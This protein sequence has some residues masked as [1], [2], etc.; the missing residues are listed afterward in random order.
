MQN[1]L[2]LINHAG[3][4]GTERYVYSLIANAE[5]F[6]VK[7]FFAYHEKGLLCDR[8]T[9]L[10]GVSVFHVPMRSPFDFKAARAIAAIC[11]EHQIEVIHTNY[12]RENYNAIIAKQRHLKTLK[13]VYTNHFVIHNSAAVKL[14]NRMMTK[15]DH[16]IISVCQ[17]G[18]EQLKENGND[19]SKIVV[20]HNAVEPEIWNPGA[21]YTEI[22]SKARSAYGIT[23]GEKLLICASRF[24]HDKGHHYFINAIELFATENPNAKFMLAGDGPLIEEIRQRV[25]NAGLSE[26]V[27]FIGFV[28]DIRAL[29]YAADIY[30]NPSQH[31]A[32][33]FLILEALAS[34][35]PVIAADMGGNREIVNTENGCGI[36]VKYD[37]APM[38]RDAMAELCR[39]D[40][41]LAALREKAL[42]TIDR[43]HSLDSMLKRTFD[44]Y[45]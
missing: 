27:R 23:D 22:R 11:K 43:K 3:K 41:K 9:A 8:I 25:E 6:G 32:S 44:T 17:V 34:G 33:S 14:A 5:R 15:H 18:A 29:F 21:D 1:V 42:E 24:A 31:E 28:E 35:L 10:G 26:M 40:G 38:L 30:V 36:L 12:L 13:A 4:A 16:K 2:Y 37:D 45:Q 39:D 7:P 19:A 20:I